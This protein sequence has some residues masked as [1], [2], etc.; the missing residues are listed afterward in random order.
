MKLIL[1]LIVALNLFS[2]P[3]INEIRRIYPEAHNS[4]SSAKELSIKLAKVNVDSDK[5]LVA[6]K[7]ASITLLSKF[8]NKIADKIA[9]FKEGSKLVELAVAAEPDNVEIRMIRLSIQE[10]IPKFINYRKNKKED[11][12][13]ILAHYKE[14]PSALKTYLKVFILQSKSFSSEEKQSIK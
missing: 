12:D 4:E 11:K 7:G 14:Q 3:D 5:T 2:S 1:S 10:N 9:N 6:Y 13:F 8:A